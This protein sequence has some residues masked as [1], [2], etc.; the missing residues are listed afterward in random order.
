[1]LPAQKFRMDYMY[2]QAFSTFYR[3]HDLATDWHQAQ[4][5]CEAEGTALLIPNSLEEMENLK[6]LMSNL[7]AHSTAIFVGLHDKFSDGDFVTLKGEP[8]TGTV[9]ELIWAPGSPDNMKGSEHCVVMT[10]DGLLD[11]R[12]CNDIYPF[13][14]K[15]LGNDTKFNKKCNCFDVGYAPGPKDNGKCYKFHM[16]PLSWHDAYLICQ[17]EEGH[18]AIATSD[19]EATLITSFLNNLQENKAP[20]PNILLIGFSDLMFPFEYRTLKGETLEKAGYALWGPFTDNISEM[21][22]KRCGAMS[23]TGQLLMTRC[24]LPAMFLCEM[25]IVI[26]KDDDASDEAETSAETVTEAIN[27]TETE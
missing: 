3:L 2:A 8:I 21:T 17:E 19:E 4:Q 22:A 9:L 26:A 14:C 7:K 13:V 18:L 5:I 15:I 24:D 20:N 16:E 6:I 23:R 27:K 11:D 25:A 10:R 12:P 1:M